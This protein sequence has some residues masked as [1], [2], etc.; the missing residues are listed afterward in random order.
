MKKPGEAEFTKVA[1]Q[2]WQLESYNYTYTNIGTGENK[3]FV[4]VYDEAG[5]YTDS[6][7][8]TGSALA[9]LPLSVPT[10]ELEGTGPIN[11][12]YTSNVKVKITPG[13][14]E[15]KTVKGIRYAVTGANPIAQTDVDGTG[16]VE[17][18]LKLNGTSTIV[19]RTRYTDGNESEIRTVEVNINKNA[20]NPVDPTDP[21]KPVDPDL[22]TGKTEIKIDVSGQTG[23]NGYYKSAVTVN[24]E[25]TSNVAEIAGI[26]Y[27]VEGA[28]AVK[29]R[30]VQGS[31]KTLTIKADGLSTVTAY[32]IDKSGN[33]SKPVSREIKK[34]QRAP[35][36][37][38]ITPGAPTTTM[39]PVTVKAIDNV[40]GI[41]AYEFEY[42]QNSS[43][44]W[45][46]KDIIRTN[47]ETYDY[48]YT[49]LREKTKYNI[50]IT[51]IDNAGNSRV[52]TI[53]TIETAETPD[54]T[55]PSAPTITV[56]GLAGTNGW[57]RGDV[58]VRIVP[59]KDTDSGVKG[60]KYWIDGAQNQASETTNTVATKSLTITKN[61]ISTITAYT[62]DKAGN[63][64]GYASKVVKK[65]S[66]APSLA[67]LEIRTK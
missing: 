66:D 56:S 17:I 2:E 20:M 65:D 24:I 42:K 45:N 49:G 40:S 33:V 52:S 1:E 4:R 41:A 21:S 37:L 63:V 22:P 59:G 18:E 51:A 23:A 30:T 44:I 36:T 57:H 28:G 62:I 38:N 25:A 43:S 48:V 60:I 11:D 67:T 13:T 10:I 55:A 15:G 61:G 32:A 39:I 46:T 35:Q 12:Y 53:Y 6:E 26:K 29:E 58:V 16:T 8:K 34:D 47:E 9:E 14:M 54:T 50:R 3:M 19:A 31:T 5:N 64:S 7:E 27:K